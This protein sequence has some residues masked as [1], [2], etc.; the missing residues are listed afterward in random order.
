MR[1][2]NYLAGFGTVLIFIGLYCFRALIRKDVVKG[3][4]QNPK[5][6]SKTNKVIILISGIVSFVLG[7]IL[8][9]KS[10]KLI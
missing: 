6:I 1:G 3:Y 5:V 9:I 8:I 4:I 10:L 2:I 7:L